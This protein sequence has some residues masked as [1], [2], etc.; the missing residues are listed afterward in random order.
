MSDK[1]DVLLPEQI[2]ETGPKSITDIAKQT[3][4]SE[5]SSRGKLLKDIEKYDAI[6]ARG[7]LDFDQDLLSRSAN[8]KV[9]SKHGVGVDNVD[10]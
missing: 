3:W 7:D 1:W 10:I 6:I 4:L 9:I 2:N 8:L 5:Y